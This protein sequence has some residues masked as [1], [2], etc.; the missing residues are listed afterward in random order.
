[1]NNKG[2]TLIEIIGVVV[3]L[4][5]IMA[6][7]VPAVSNYIFNSRKTSYISSVSAYSETIMGYYEQK[8]FGRLLDDNEVLIVPFENIELESGETTKSPFGEYV[9]DKSYLVISS[10][11][12]G[13]TYYVSV[14]DTEN[15][16]FDMKSESEITKNELDK[17]DYNSVVSWDAYRSGAQDIH[18]NGSDYSFCST[19]SFNG[20]DDALILMCKTDSSL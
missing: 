15:Y 19:R 12:K 20:K 8:E 17:I 16:G 14:I 4:S 2:F 5:L 7:S 9:L 6:I 3:I 1:M 13:Y 18:I 11:G 10:K